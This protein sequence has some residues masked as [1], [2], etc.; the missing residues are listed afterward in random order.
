M[1]K[2]AEEG[3]IRVIVEAMD[4]HGSN[5]GVQESGCWALLNVGWIRS[6][7][8]RQIREEGGGRL[9]SLKR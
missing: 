1:V 9:F 6:D 7:L 2:V 5:A 4:Q 8:Q 3:G